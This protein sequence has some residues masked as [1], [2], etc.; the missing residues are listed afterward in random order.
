MEYLL[1]FRGIERLV[2]LKKR[3]Q[4]IVLLPRM[5][6][7]LYPKDRMPLHEVQEAV[8]SAIDGVV[9]RGISSPEQLPARALEGIRRSIPNLECAR[10][11]MR[12]EYV[13]FRRTPVTKQE[14][15]EM[16]QV[17]ARASLEKGEIVP[18]LGAEVTGI[19][20]CPCAHEGLI[21]KTRE[22]L[23]GEFSE[24]EIR[25]I[26]NLVPVASH[27]Q[28]NVSTL[29]L[30]VSEG[31]KIEVDSIIEILENSM[32]SR[33]YE[34]LKR[35]DEV[36]VVYR[37]H[38]NPNFVEDTVRKILVPWRTS[39]HCPTARWCMRRAR[40]WRASTSTTPSPSG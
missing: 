27:N 33:L 19:T 26:F 29:M 24:E 39:H 32:S 28:R 12:A 4:V 40:A 21:E 36:E 5:E 7:F 16:Y 2:E 20:A 3:G 9:E 31:E 18:M 1:G 25:T 13:V 22:R 35:E 30:S 14:T 38:L 11:E 8:T 37:A 6:V 23:R 15:Q 10:I 17:L 34:V